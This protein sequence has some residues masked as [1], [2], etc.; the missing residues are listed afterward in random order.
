MLRRVSV[1]LSLSLS[2][3]TSALEPSGAGTWVADLIVRQQVISMRLAI[4]GSDITGSGSLAD[5]T[6]TLGDPLN[7]TGVRYADTLDI[8]FR[9]S[10]ADPF[11]FVGWYTFRGTIDG[12]LDGAEFNREAVSFRDR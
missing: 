7:L 1:A 5:L 6:A 11:R 3:C 10:V 8:T 12:T 2:A 4:D 9:R